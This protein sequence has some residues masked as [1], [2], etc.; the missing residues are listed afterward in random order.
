MASASVVKK[1]AR[2]SPS[3]RA[4]AERRATATNPP[5]AAVGGKL[6][7]AAG[8]VAL[9]GIIAGTFV[10]DGISDQILAA[11]KMTEK[12]PVDMTKWQPGKLEDI[13]ITLVTADYDKLACAFDRE[14]GGAHCEYKTETERWPEDP[15]APAD[16][17]KKNVLQPYSA[18]P[19][20]ALVL[21]AGLWAQPAVAMRLHA[22]PPG[23]TPAKN[24]AR[25]IAKCRVKPVERVDNASI[26]WNTTDKWARGLLRAG[27]QQVA[28]WVAIVDSC[29]VWDE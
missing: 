22:E 28:P 27:D 29:S 14:V 9:M 17:N 20:N 3:S 25:F 1:P 10:G 16:N 13:E 5:P 15:T 18:V 21:L 24:L 23:N 11:L 2:P 26:R 12:P 7:I 4:P 19:D 6:Y 8:I